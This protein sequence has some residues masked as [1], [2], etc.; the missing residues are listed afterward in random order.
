MTP[1]HTV[2]SR[3]T[4]RPHASRSPHLTLD[5]QQSDLRTSQTLRNTD[6]SLRLPSGQ[7]RHKNRPPVRFH[8]LTR[9]CEWKFTS[10]FPA[11]PNDSAS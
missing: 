3:A 8:L 4:A 9:L 10:L 11:A 1:E 6:F 2:P 7:D 5:L